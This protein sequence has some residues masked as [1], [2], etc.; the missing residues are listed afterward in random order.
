[1]AEFLEVEDVLLMHADQV[2]RYG[3]EH[4]VRDL[5]LLESAVAQPRATFGGQLLHDDLIEMAAAYLFHL[6]Q[7]HPF[8]DG[9]KRAGLVAAL[10]FLDLNDVELEVAPGE[11]HDLTLRAA[12]GRAGKPE[13]AAFLRERVVARG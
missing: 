8:F 2:A 1:M 9:N 5:G 6:V 13:I 12:T 3:G 4:G 11:L 7:N 10:A